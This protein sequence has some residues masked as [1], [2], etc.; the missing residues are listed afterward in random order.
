MKMPTAAGSAWAADIAQAKARLQALHESCAARIHTVP[1]GEGV[2]EA[3][4]DGEE[5]GEENLEEI[6]PNTD[7]P[8]VYANVMIEE[9][10]NIS[11][12]SDR[13]RNPNDP[14]YDMKIPPAT[15]DEAMLRTDRNKWL[16]AMKK[17]LGIMND[18]HVYRLAPLP[19]GHKAI[20]NRWV[21]EF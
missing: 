1:S 10:A 3:E 5:D 19:E 18:M 20:G 12:R 15:Y 6:E 9:H 14:N 13:K 8:E 16:I 11:I 2:T 21:L 4:K 17:E 7:V